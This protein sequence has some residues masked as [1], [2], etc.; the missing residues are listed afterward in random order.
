MTMKTELKNE[1]VGDL[2]LDFCDVHERLITS[3]IQEAQL[4]KLVKRISGYVFSIY[5][6]G[7]GCKDLKMV[8]QQME[9]DHSGACPACH[10]NRLLQSTYHLLGL[11]GITKSIPKG[12]VQ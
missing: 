6:A 10:W 11:L 8:V 12:M 2:E 4:R 1:L 7:N 5:M 9:E 3:Q